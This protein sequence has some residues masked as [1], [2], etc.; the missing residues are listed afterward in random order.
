MVNCIH[1]P[2]LPDTGGQNLL[3]VHHA[4]VD[5]PHHIEFSNERHHGMVRT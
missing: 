4:D 5:G 2:N 1:D 3:D